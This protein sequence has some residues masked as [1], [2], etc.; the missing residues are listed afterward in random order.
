M[1]GAAGLIVINYTPRPLKPAG[2]TRI[3]L[4][5]YG[6]AA[7]PSG[8]TTRQFPNPGNW[9]ANN[10]IE[11]VGPGGGGSGSPI[12]DINNAAGSGGGGGAYA[13]ATNLYPTFPVGFNVSQ[14]SGANQP[15]NEQ[16]N[17]TW[18]NNFTQSAGNI[19][20]RAGAS[21]QSFAAQSSNSTPGAGGNLAYPAGFNGATGGAGSQNTIN[22][23]TGGGGGGGAGGPN[24][25]GA[26][27]AANSGNVSGAGGASDGGHTP[28]SSSNGISGTQWDHL[29]GI[30]GA[31][32][33]GPDL[34]T[35][36]I[37][38]NFG[39]GG[40]GSLGNASYMTA[41]GPAPLGAG[42]LIVIT[43]T[44]RNATRIY[45]YPI[46]PFIGSIIP[47][48]TVPKFPNPG[49]WNPTNNKVECVGS[50]GSGTQGWAGD[51]QGNAGAGG[52]GGGYAWDIN[53][54]PTFPVNFLN[55]PA[56][57]EPDDDQYNSV[58]WNNY[59]LTPGTVLAGFGHPAYGSVGSGAG[60]STPGNGGGSPGGGIGSSNNY[61]ANQSYIGGAG[62]GGGTI[63]SVVTGG[64]SGGGG[65]GPHG[66]GLAGANGGAGV[67][68]LAG[69]A[70]DNGNSP[71]VSG[72][73]TNG[74]QWDSLHGVGSGGSSAASGT[75]AA[76]GGGLFG[77]GGGGGFTMGS[78]SAGGPASYGLIV[79]TYTP[80]IPPPPQG[81][82]QII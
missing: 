49:N 13:F 19:I 42:G 14:S 33:G 73:A 71:G 76:I 82:V 61:P 68:S 36:L 59:T 32:A 27:G 52:G 26:V 38:G 81:Q 53:L 46:L 37:A 15:F 58:W 8:G 31:C 44:P 4:Y 63:A 75:T 12:A 40:G 67:P 60:N 18:W 29:H 9:T 22:T 21:G 2:A 64:G 69:G 34:T 47:N 5:Q 78:G 77:G 16:Q 55:S 6:P 54:N 43:Y 70:G 17:S 79:I 3:Y 62:G 10:M 50:G 24:G 28:G 56:Q 20:G 1:T 35:R 41:G 57:P 72:G 66:A 23:G 39:G 11:C 80:K 74:T 7:F 51:V 45:L 30:G 25:A 65:A 48:N